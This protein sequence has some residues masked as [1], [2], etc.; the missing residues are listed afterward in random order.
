MLV[1]TI[2]F[3]TNTT[4]AAATMRD[5]LLGLGCREWQ[6]VGHHRVYLTARVCSRAIGL[7]VST[8]GS[9]NV[10]SATL[11]GAKISNRGAAELLAAFDGAYYDVTAEKFVTTSGYTREIAASLRAQFTAAQAEVAA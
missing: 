9:G 1:R 6:R 4:N 11:D 2:G 5:M 7:R 8:Y 3:M 10:S